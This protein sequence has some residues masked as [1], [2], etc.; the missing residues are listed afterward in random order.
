MKRGGLF[1]TFEGPE[2]SGKTTQ[3]RLLAD[4]L[5]KSRISYVTTREPGGSKLNTYLRHWLLD[6]S[7]YELSHEAELFLFLADRTQHVLEV[8]R[9]PLEKGKLVISDRFADS[10]LAYQ[11]G[12]RGFPMG[13]L[14]KMN[15]TAVKGLKPDLT[16]LFDVP[17]KIGLSRAEASKGRRDRMEREP[18]SF[19]EKVRKTF[20]RIAKSEPKRFLILDSRK[21]QE[22]VFKDL[23]QGLQKR[24]PEPWKGKLSRAF[25]G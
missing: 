21:N 13:L 25:H 6:Q 16:V 9:P 17:V 1:I 15:E 11:G 4:V 7:D 19:H 10:T 20:L 12:G 24:L 18:L 8:L 2:G 23:I 3:M 22:A 5:G 14:R